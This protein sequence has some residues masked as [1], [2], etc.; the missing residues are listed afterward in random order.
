[1]ERI[2]SLTTVSAAALMLSINAMAQ[3]APESAQPVYDE[4]IVTGE[5]IARSLQDTPTSVAVVTNVDIKERNIINIGELMQQ[6]ANVST[7][8]GRS[9]TIRGINNQNVSGSGLA[10][11]ATMYVDGAPVARTAAFSG[12][13]DMWDIK[14]VEILRGP[15]STLQGRNTLAGAIVVS[16]EDPSYEWGGKARAII[17]TT[18]RE[19]RLAAAIGGPI[20]D[21]QIAFRLA[22]EISDTRGLVENLTVGNFED[23]KD[24]T[25]LRGKLLIEPKAIPNLSAMLTYIHDERNTGNNNRLMDSRD[26]FEEPKI[27]SDLNRTNNLVMDMGV[28]RI[29]YDLNDS[30]TLSSI[31]TKTDVRLER[32][33]DSDFTA[34]PDEFHQFNDD[35]DIFTQEV[36]LSFNTGALT[37]IV[38]G[39]YSKNDRLLDFTS[40]QSIDVVND[41]GLVNS[42]V[43]L[44]GLPVPTAAFVASFYAAPVIIQAEGINPIEV[45]TYAI[46]GDATYEISPSIRL[47]GGFRYDKERQEITTGNSVAIISDLPDPALFPPQLGPVI[48]GVN[49]FLHQQATNATQQAVELKSPTFGAFL[50]KA[51]ISWDITEEHTMSFM[52]QR[53]YRS[54]GVGVNTARAETFEF[55]QEYTWNYELSWRSRWLDNALTLNANAFFINWSDQQV[56][57]QLSGNSFDVVTQNAGSSEVKGFEIESLYH[58]NDMLD[59]YGSIGYAHTKFKEFFA[60]VNGAQ[61]DL[62]GNSFLNAPRWTLNAG[63][64]WKNEQGFFVNTN[65]NY[66]SAKFFLSSVVQTDHDVGARLF[67]N[68]KAGWNNETYG[69]FVAANNLFNE[70]YLS[71]YFS[72]DNTRAFNNPEF[73]TFALPRTI[74]LQLEVKF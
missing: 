44:F 6:T 5:K 63:F 8:S 46:F 40:T 58:V 61:I 50:P 10:D 12:P 22:G 26:P 56:D 52:V 41:L 19:K 31:S 62:A 24:S 36:R 51:G 72:R 35:E 16:T 66:N 32:G 57:V 7:N 53:G 27:L 21:E 29:D 18:A 25:Y 47:F 68:A 55:D 45:E 4:I 49:G 1:M 71:S 59:V 73:G 67:V 9:Y 23:A 69:I 48:A 20:V 17:G 28:L 11:L 64:T 42:L 15:Q 34:Q 70:N 74:A 13:L 38:G 43:N 30:L 37:G 3:T 65:A 60:S 33:G 54:G 14:Q 2:T 39:F